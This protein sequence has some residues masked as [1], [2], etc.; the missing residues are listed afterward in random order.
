MSGDS[1]YLAAALLSVNFTAQVHSPKQIPPGGIPTVPNTVWYRLSQRK[2]RY[3]H[4]RNF[5]ETDDS[6]SRHKKS[7]RRRKPIQRGE[8]VAVRWLAGSM[9]AGFVRL[10]SQRVSDLGEVEAVLVMM[11]NI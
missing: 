3:R 1:E 4:E 10:A 9:E 5:R 2:R 11:P 6:G 8:L 7:E